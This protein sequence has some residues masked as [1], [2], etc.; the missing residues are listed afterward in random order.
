MGGHI[1]QAT[2][3]EQARK[4]LKERLYQSTYF[5]LAIYKIDYYIEVI[6]LLYLPHLNRINNIV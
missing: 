4:Q 2:Q 1:K 6:T 5:H 3:S